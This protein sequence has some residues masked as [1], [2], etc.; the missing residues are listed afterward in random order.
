MQENNIHITIGI[1]GLVGAGKTSLCRELLKI[2]PNSVLLH[3]GNLYR[4]IIVALMNS[5]MDLNNILKNNLANKKP[6]IKRVMDMLQVEIKIEDRESVVYVAGKKIDEEELQSD[7]AS[8]AVSNVAMKVD[9]SRLYSFARELIDGLKMDSNV[10]ISGR[11]LMQIYPNLDYHFFVTATIEER[12]RRKASQYEKD[13]T[14]TTRNIDLEKLREHIV[15]RD[16]LQEK[17]GYYKRYANTIDID[18]TNCKSA[19]ESAEKLYSYI[20]GE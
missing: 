13:I 18:V 3:G 5:K 15:K 10:I 20:R 8:M 14:S 2:I 1:E 16:E 17:A 7:T 6:D 4:G 9:N 12:V 19:K 11:D